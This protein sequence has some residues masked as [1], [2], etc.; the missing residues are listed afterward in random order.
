MDWNLF[1]TILAQV[2]I[3]S[4]TVRVLFIPW[5]GIFTRR[6]ESYTH[7]EQIL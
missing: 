1:W 4:L 5:Q 6:Y 3:A 2:T 7:T